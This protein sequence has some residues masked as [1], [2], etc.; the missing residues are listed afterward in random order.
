MSLAR[1]RPAFHGPA[2]LDSLPTPV[3]LAT[4]GSRTQLV[5]LAQIVAVTGDRVHSRLAS[6]LRGNRDVS[7]LTPVGFTAGERLPASPQ[8]LVTV[9]ADAI[10]GHV[11]QS[12]F[13]LLGISSGGLL[14]FEVGKRLAASGVRP[15]AAVLVDTYAMDDVRL[16]GF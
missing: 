3:R 7:S 1:V 12:S 11:G 2:D 6:A 16:T 15:T 9:L 5:C 10:A 13:A 4:G 8:A 14:A